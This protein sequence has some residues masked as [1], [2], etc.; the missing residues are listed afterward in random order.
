ML[1]TRSCHQLCCEQPA[2]SLAGSAHACLSLEPQLTP[3]LS[4]FP[5]MAWGEAAMGVTS[6]SFSHFDPGVFVVGV[7]GGYSLRCSTAAQTPALLRQ[8]GS[9]PL[10]APAELTF[11]PHAG[12]V[13]SVS[14][15]P[16]HRQVLHVGHYHCQ[17]LNTEFSNSPWGVYK[18]QKRGSW[19]WELPVVGRTTS[20]GPVEAAYWNVLHVGT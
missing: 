12:P 1:K 19:Y 17:A 4:L 7:E 13:Y 2:G 9:V 16:F 14:C 20:T 5:Q 11:S 10:R 3:A 15:S 8:G 6:L 18:F